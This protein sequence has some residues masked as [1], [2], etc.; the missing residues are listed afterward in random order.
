MFVVGLVL[1][2]LGAAASYHQG[3]V[4]EGGQDV[5]LTESHWK[6]TLQYNLTQ[7]EMEAQNLSIL[8]KTVKDHFH[9]F[10]QNLLVTNISNHSPLVELEASFR[11]EYG[12]LQQDVSEYLG[13]VEDLLTLLPRKRVKRGLIDA[14]G[15]VLKYLFGTLDSSDLEVLDD[16][17]NSLYD[18]NEQLTHDHNEQVTV[19]ANMQAEMVTHA[20]TINTILGTLKEYH[21]VL[22]QSITKFFKRTEVAEQQLKQL[23]K[24]LKL[25]S[26]LAET[27][28]TVATAMLKMSKFHQAIEEL[29][30]GKVS[31]KLLPPHEFLKLLQ[32]IEKVLPPP[33]KF[34]LP[35][36]LENIHN[37]YSVATVH[38][39]TT[40]H[41]LRVVM[42][43]PLRND[44]KLFQVYDVISYPVYD[45]ALQRWAKWDLQG[46]KLMI[47]KDRLLYSM[48][49]E[50]RFNRE[51]QIGELTVCPLVDVLLSIH[52]RPS[53]AVELFVKKTTSLCQ[54]KLISGIVSPALIRT[55]SRWLYSASQEHKLTLNCYDNKGKE[56]LTYLTIEGIGEL[57]GI[58]GCEVIDGDFKL[59]ARIQGSSL[60][61]EHTLKVAFPDIR[62]MYT[63]AETELM[64]S[65]LNATLDILK[66][67]DEELGTL[68]VK[69]YPLEGVLHRIRSHHHFWGRIKYVKVAA[70]GSAALLMGILTLYLCFRVRS[71]L[72]SWVMRCQT[73]RRERRAAT[74]TSV[75]EAVR[76]PAQIR[77]TLPASQDAPEET[78]A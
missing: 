67:L 7:V 75:L 57:A 32:E 68:G 78:T 13:E 74:L 39:Y 25:S 44:A 20:K 2:L 12:M 35:P 36:S 45:K 38:S 30:G 19:L 24:Y 43:M 63:E 28:D 65:D 27:K 26:A 21:T 41:T 47:S 77:V 52:T 14:G 50:H 70:G 64:N 8:V 61:R 4:F 16:K 71:R 17:L 62:A 69:E 5:L 54:R 59:P 3:V 51:C 23:F 42:Q 34:Y 72:F 56:N 10:F 31:S 29:A 58:R 46:Q 18:T 9:V 6:V 55:P 49:D 73:R 15:H 22:H 48:Y 53:C 40:A 37:F 76:Q 60:F 1:I 66:G 11:Y 33:V